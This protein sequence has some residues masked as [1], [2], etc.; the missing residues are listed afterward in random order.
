M[1][2][3]STPSGPSVVNTGIR[4]TPDGAIDVETY[5]NDWS[6]V[7]APPLS[8][9]FIM[10][11]RAQAAA[12]FRQWLESA[13]PS[14]AVVGPSQEEALAFVAAAIQSEAEPR[15]EVLSANTVIVSTPESFND[16]VG[17]PSPLLLVSHSPRF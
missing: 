16:L 14:V 9:S 8:L 3:F 13:T 2:G 12:S 15:R 17:S 5:W 4:K 6:Q 10:A 11:G 7:T 1:D